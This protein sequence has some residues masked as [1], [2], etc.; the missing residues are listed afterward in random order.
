M[1]V[2]VIIHISVGSEKST[3]YFSQDRLSI[4]ADETCDLQIQT[5]QIESTGVWVELEDTEGVYRITRFD[6][7]LTFTLNDKPIRRFIAVTDGDILK[8][9]DTDVALSFFSVAAKASLI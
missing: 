2:G 3:E 5:S 9:D 4:G 8:I 7:S 1:A 6:P